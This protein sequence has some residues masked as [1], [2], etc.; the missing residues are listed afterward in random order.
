MT[1]KTNFAMFAV[2]ASV[3]MIGA[4]APAFAYPY[5]EVLSVTAVSGSSPAVDNESMYVSGCGTLYS[6]LKAY[7]SQNK[8][9]LWFNASACP[10]EYDSVYG[11][12]EVKNHDGTVQKENWTSTMT[13][14]GFWFYTSV[15]AGDIVTG[16]LIYYI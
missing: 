11:E 6:S 1:N 12:V 15:Q 7:E 5:Y 14:G 16:N 2:V 8:V 10:S 3:L 9:Q 13:T 4:V